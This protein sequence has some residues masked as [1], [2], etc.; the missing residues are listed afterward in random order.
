MKTDRRVKVSPAPHTNGTRRPLPARLFLIALALAASSLVTRTH[1][2]NMFVLDE[3]T[4]GERYEF[5]V[6]TA[7]TAPF[8]WVYLDGTPPPGLLFTPDGKLAGTPDPG[9][10]STTPYRFK[11]RVTDS[12]PAR[13]STEQWLSVT[14]APAPSLIN[15]TNQT[16]LPAPTPTPP[17]PPAFMLTTST[18]DEE[19]IALTERLPVAAP[20]PNFNPDTD[21]ANLANLQT[22]IGNTIGTNRENFQEGDYSVVHV[23]WW[24]PVNTENKS[25]PDREIWALFRAEDGGAGNVRWEPVI[26]PKNAGVFNTRILGRKRVAVLL[27]HLNTPNAWDVKYE[28]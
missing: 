21:P 11:V 26:D 20:T 27:A 17:P 15:L 28:V 7:G 8:T 5:Q 14:V 19:T 18:A 1:A 12:S 6:T 2:Q 9:S 16:V 23:I 3:A 24:K 25:E 4:E 13:R 22:I 10:A